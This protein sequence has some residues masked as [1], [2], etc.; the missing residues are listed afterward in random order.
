MK[1]IELKN[2]SLLL[3]LQMV[4]A[5]YSYNFFTGLPC[6]FKI[7]LSFLCNIHLHYSIFTSIPSTSQTITHMLYKA[8][9][10]CF[11]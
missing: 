4:V 10:T 8:G 5:I 7:L 1:K 6:S 9:N 2:F 11:L 3:H